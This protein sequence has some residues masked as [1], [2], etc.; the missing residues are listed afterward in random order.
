[1]PVYYIPEGVFGIVVVG[2]IALLAL[3]TLLILYIFVRESS[4]GTIW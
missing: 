2:A 4:A 1:M 3:F